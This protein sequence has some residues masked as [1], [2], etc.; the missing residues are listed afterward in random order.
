M[1]TLATQISLRNPRYLIWNN[2]KP[3]KVPKMNILKKSR[4]GG[5]SNPTK[6]TLSYDVGHRDDEY[7][8]RIT[9]NE[10]GGSEVISPEDPNLGTWES[11]KMAEVAA[12]EKSPGRA[13]VLH[14][15][16]VKVRRSVVRTTDISSN[17]EH[18]LGSTE[19]KNSAWFRLGKVII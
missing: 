8:L 18:Q 6:Q 5:V 7:H 14:S 15:S 2:P 11:E 4:C 3:Y 12:L 16:S 10:G 9:D 17:Y 19:T 13:T 1:L